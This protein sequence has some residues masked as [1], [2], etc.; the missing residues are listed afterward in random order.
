MA[1]RAR[2]ARRSRPFAREHPRPA[3]QCQD[4][5]PV[6]CG[7]L[8]SGKYA[9]AAAAYEVASE[10]DDIYAGLAEQARQNAETDIRTDH[11]RN[12]FQDDVVNF[13]FGETMFTIFILHASRRLQADRFFTESYNEETYTPEGLAWI[14]ANG[15]KSVALRHMPELA[16]T[17]LVNDNVT[18]IFEPFDTEPEQLNDP[19]R[20]PLAFVPR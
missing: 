20:H 2:Q 7:L 4:S 15:S 1:A 16:K 5:S 18:T 11:A 12:P 9:E 14:D 19:T 13:G 3:D 10:G 8:P 17:G 6:G